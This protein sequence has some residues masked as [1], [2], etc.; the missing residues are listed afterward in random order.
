MKFTLPI[1]DLLYT[2]L[3]FLKQPSEMAPI[4]RDGKRYTAA[5]YRDYLESEITLLRGS[6]AVLENRNGI[7]EKKNHD[8]NASLIELQGQTVL[9]EERNLESQVIWVLFNIIGSDFASLYVLN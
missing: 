4:L 8:L 9:W 2:L 7:L 1:D 3:V 5:Q 6:I